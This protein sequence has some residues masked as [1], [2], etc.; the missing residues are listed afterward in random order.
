M[1]IFR[2]V[3][4]FA[5]GMGEYTK[6]GYETAKKYFRPDDLEVDLKDRSIM[7]TGA[8]SGI[9]KVCALEGNSTSFNF[10]EGCR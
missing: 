2:N 1:S 10:K 5:K 3:I 4:W 7:V 9:G 6:P 8:N